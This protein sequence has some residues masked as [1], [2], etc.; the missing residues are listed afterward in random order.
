MD[1][2]VPESPNEV[3]HGICD[4]RDGRRVVVTDRVEGGP[5]SDPFPVST[6]LWV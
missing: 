3:S 5:T 2:E 6:C 4:G 1:G